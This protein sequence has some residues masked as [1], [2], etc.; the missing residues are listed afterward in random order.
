MF[1]FTKVLKCIITYIS[2]KI[3]IRTLWEYLVIITCT[4]TRELRK[5]Q[6]NVYAGYTVHLPDTSK[7]KQHT[8]RIYL[9]PFTCFRHMAAVFVHYRQPLS[10]YYQMPVWANHLACFV[11][12]TFMPH[13]QHPPAE[14][15]SLL[16][17]TEY[18]ASGWPEWC[19]ERSPRRLYWQ[20]L[21]S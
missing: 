10:E 1:C 12:S 16:P 19:S 6:R 15:L 4:S 2:L 3:C 8:D 21:K 18:I 17:P 11:I 20:R 13:H 9:R 7:L 5:N 14:Q